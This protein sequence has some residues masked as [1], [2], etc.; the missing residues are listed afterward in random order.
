MKRARGK[1]CTHDD[2]SIGT[3]VQVAP[4]RGRWRRGD[5]VFWHKHR[6]ESARELL[7]GRKCQKEDAQCSG[8]RERE[9]SVCIQVNQLKIVLDE[10]SMIYDDIHYFAFTFS[11]Q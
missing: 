6:Y 8:E 7:N 1:Q 9:G 4:E 5:A 10:V 11:T 3:R 2:C